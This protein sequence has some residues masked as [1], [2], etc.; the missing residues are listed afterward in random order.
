MESRWIVRLTL[1]FEQGVVGKAELITGGSIWSP[2]K[3]LKSCPIQKLGLLI[4]F[5]LFQ[6]GAANLDWWGMIH[7]VLA[8]SSPLIKFL[9]RYMQ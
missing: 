8:I 9:E 7:L 2:F 1:T 6:Y 5:A 4:H 3:R